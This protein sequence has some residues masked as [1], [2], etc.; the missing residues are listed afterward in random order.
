M[1][2]ITGCMLGI[3]A[4]FVVFTAGLRLLARLLGAIAI[5]L[6][7]LTRTDLGWLG[8]ILGILVVCFSFVQPKNREDIA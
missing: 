7:V 4:A 3:V 6:G 5:I 2:E 8:L 1:I